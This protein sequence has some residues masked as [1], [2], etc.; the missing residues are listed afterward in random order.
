MQEPSHEPTSYIARESHQPVNRPQ[1]S[2]LVHLPETKT[3][4]LPVTPTVIIRLV[5]AWLV[6][7]FVINSVAMHYVGQ[8]KLSETTPAR[9]GQMRAHISA[10]EERTSNIESLNIYLQNYYAKFATYPS[11][12]QINSIEFRKADPSFKVANR[13]TYM[14][15]LGT[16]SNL[17][18][19]PA[20]NVYFYA[21]LPAGCDS[22]KVT[23]T[24]Y[25]VGATLDN[26][27]LYTKQNQE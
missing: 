14:D 18:T 1:G 26:G 23:C 25:T 19:Q 6:L 7:L 10:D 5:V 16:T 3:A 2:F 12:A 27:Q 4:I 9:S 21:P 15:P 11:T 13:R 22:S 17:A 20:K 8:P 24:G